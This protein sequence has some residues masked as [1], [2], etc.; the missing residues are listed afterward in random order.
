MFVGQHELAHVVTRAFRC[1]VSSP[2]CQRRTLIVSH[3][4]FDFNLHLS[5]SS[6][7]HF[8]LSFLIVQIVSVHWLQPIMISNFPEGYS[9]S[10]LTVST[11]REILSMDSDKAS[12]DDASRCSEFTTISSKGAW[13]GTSEG[14]LGKKWEILLAT[15][16]TLWH[17]NLTREWISTMWCGS[18]SLW[19]NHRTLPHRAW[20]SPRFGPFQF[21]KSSC[22]ARQWWNHRFE[23]QRMSASVFPRVQSRGKPNTLA[24][25]T[26]VFEILRLQWKVLRW[27]FEQ[28]VEEHRVR[29]GHYSY[30]WDRLSTTLS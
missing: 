6:S 28:V 19:F 13:V 29:F 14:S 26:K 22:E 7:T 15:I 17:P 5:N 11:D 10:S 24:R 1:I 25:W 30:D 9:T 18:Q 2:M 23:Y 12:V 20:H 4:L 27:W 16:P 3:E 21:A 8:S